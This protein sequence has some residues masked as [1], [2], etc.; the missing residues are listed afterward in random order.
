MS[1]RIIIPH[2]VKKNLKKLPKQMREKFYWCLNMLLE[3]EN[4]PSL[5]N[6][7]IKGTQNYWEFSITMNYRC[8]YRKEKDTIYLLAIGKH[9][10]VF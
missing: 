6:K 9:E 3:D 8:I 2:S 1:K 5:R 7:K 10:G 4:H